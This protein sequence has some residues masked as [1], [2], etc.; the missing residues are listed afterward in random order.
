MALLCDR[1]EY[2]YIINSA[3]GPCERNGSSLLGM[4]ICE[5]GRWQKGGSS[6]NN[7]VFLLS[8]WAKCILWE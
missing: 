2:A 4:S 1:I 8:V 7:G 6:V 3:W 5:S